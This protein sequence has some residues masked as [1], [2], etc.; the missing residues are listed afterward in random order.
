MRRGWKEKEAK[1]KGRTNRA[2]WTEDSVA[3]EQRAAGG[4]SSGLEAA[5][6][7]IGGQRRLK[8]LTGKVCLCVG[9]GG[10]MLL[11]PLGQR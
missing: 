5:A 1:A 7:G 8:R 10:Q 2:R 6:V 9:F 3:S 11:Q 4:E